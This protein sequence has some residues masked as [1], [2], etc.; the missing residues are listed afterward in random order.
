[1]PKPTP[2]KPFV[3]NDET[4]ENTYGFSILTAGIDLKR[5]LKNPVMLSDHYNSNWNVIG[6][7]FDVKKDKG[8][9]HGMPDF[10]TEDQDTALIAGKV[11]RGYIKGC[12][13]GILF[14]Q[15]NLKIID[16]KVILTKCELVEVSIVPVPSNANSVRLMHSDGKVMDEKEIQELSLSVIPSIKNPELNLNQDNMKKI[17][18]SIATLMALGY[19]D[20]P[21]DGL[22]MTEVDSK[23][24]GLSK[25][26]VELTSENDTLKLAAKTAKEKQESEAK[27]RISTKVDLA[28]TKG[29]FKADQ[30][31]E[32]VK[33]GIAS[34]SALDTVIGSIPV[35][36]NFSGGIVVPNG[37]GSTEVK[38]MDEFEKLDHEQKLSFKETNPEAYKKLFNQ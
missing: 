22:D 30:K 5:F 19:K 32:M 7:W 11:E 37:N 17:V 23:V 14:D 3:F 35:K 4:I 8:L 36:Q 12:S 26:V 10:D 27:L 29:Q 13:M 9:L 15:E 16:D 31:E 38:T 25:Q 2:I 28:I 33:L 6:S 18:L 1:M 20:Q 21:A 34:E 24:L